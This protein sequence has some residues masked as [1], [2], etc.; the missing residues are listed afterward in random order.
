LQKVENYEFGHI[1]PSKKEG[2]TKHTSKAEKKVVDKA[3]LIKSAKKYYIGGGM[4]SC[5]QQ[6][7][8]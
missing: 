3:L 8:N 2:N 7:Q 1:K 5:N 4:T 6:L